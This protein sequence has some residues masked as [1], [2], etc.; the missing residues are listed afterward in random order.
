MKLKQ[1]KSLGQHWLTDRAVLQEIAELA[2]GSARGGLVGKITYHLKRCR[3][4]GLWQILQRQ[5]FLLYLE[6][7]GESRFLRLLFVLIY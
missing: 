6:T 3:P 5:G 2:S 1:K 7:K 4:E